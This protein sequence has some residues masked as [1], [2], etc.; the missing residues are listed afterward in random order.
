MLTHAV[1]LATGV[2]YRQLEARASMSWSG[3]GSTTARLPPSGSP[4]L[5]IM[6]SSSAARTQPDKQPSISPDMYKVTMAVRGDSLQK[7]MS[8]YLIEQ[9]A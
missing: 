8:S 5:A 3:A 1:V 4:A 9:I 6:S 2:S 7:S